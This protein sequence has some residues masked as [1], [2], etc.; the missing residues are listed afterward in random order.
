[1]PK[2]FSAC[3]RAC[4]ACRGD[5]VH[6]TVVAADAVG[7]GR[8]S[9]ESK[10]EGM[11]TVSGRSDGRERHGAMR[12]KCVCAWLGCGSVAE[13]LIPPTDPFAS[14]KVGR[15]GGITLR[16]WT[17][18]THGGWCNVNRFGVRTREWRGEGQQ[19]HQ[20]CNTVRY[21][22]YTE[23]NLRCAQQVCSNTVQ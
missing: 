6:C 2:A 5:A 11:T 23:A 4:G 8:A 9:Q 16:A 7:R 12:C 21:I 14:Q 15:V 3:A 22:H 17:G 1:M 10:A 19:K 13:A 20:L 18:C